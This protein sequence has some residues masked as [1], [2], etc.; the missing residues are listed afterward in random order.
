MRLAGHQPD[1]LPYGGFFA[2]MLMVDR[3]VLVDHVQYEKKSFQSRNRVAGS[4]MVAL[5][6]VPVRTSGR[7]AQPITTVE[8][9]EPDGR[10]RMKHWRTLQQCYRGSPG[11]ARHAPFFDDLYHRSWSCLVDLNLSVIEYLRHCFAIPTAVHRSSGL[12]LSER[13]TTL[14]VELCRRYGA[15]EYVSGPGGLRYVDDAELVAAGVRSAYARYSPVPY[16]RLGQPFISDLSAI[17]LLFHADRDAAAL[18]RAS[19]PGPP[20][21]R[22][23]LT[24]VSP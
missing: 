2:R 24:T 21:S 15:D 1:Y 6:S 23:E 20:V 19:I 16:Q 3:F 22:E 10:W 4:G 5:L 11:F 7:F 9:S 18:L 8:I 17:D 14:L 12:G 13:R